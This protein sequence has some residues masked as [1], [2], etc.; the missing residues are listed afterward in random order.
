[1]RVLAVPSDLTNDH[2]F[3]GCALRVDDLDAVTVPLLRG[4]GRAS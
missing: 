4:L 3:R 2:D 1:M